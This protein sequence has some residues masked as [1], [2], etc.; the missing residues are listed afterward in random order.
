MDILQRQAS[1]GHP[2]PLPTLHCIYLSLRRHGD[3]ILANHQEKYFHHPSFLALTLSRI[4]CDPLP[5]PIPGPGRKSFSRKKTSRNI[6]AFFKMADNTQHQSQ[7]ASRHLHKYIF[8]AMF[9][10]PSFKS[11]AKIEIEPFKNHA[12]FQNIFFCA[13]LITSEN[14]YHAKFSEPI[15]RSKDS[16]YEPANI[17]EL[18]HSS[19]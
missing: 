11:H 6:C 2:V 13:K 10:N 16:Q 1:A 9:R 12:M 19:F 15:S 14:N 17:W 4:S 18:L 5:E 3:P 8:Y 7:L